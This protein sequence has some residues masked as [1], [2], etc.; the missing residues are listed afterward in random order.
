VLT[1]PTGFHAQGITTNAAGTALYAINS[2][3]DN[4]SEIDPKQ[5]QV[6]A[7]IAV[8]SGPVTGVVTPD[9][10]Y[11]Y[12]TNFNSGTVSVVDTNLRQQIATVSVHTPWG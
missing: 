9:G 12:V 7:T 2:D 10:A 11:L 6:V 3:G 5:D 8:G 4:V 1:I